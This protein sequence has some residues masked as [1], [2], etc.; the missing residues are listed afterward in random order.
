VYNARFLP[1]GPLETWRAFDELQRRTTSAKSAHRL[2]KA[3]G[4]LDAAEAARNL[5]APTLILHTRGDLVWSF[6]EAKELH[7]LIDRSR[8][9]PLDSRNHIL[10]AG[11]SAF[12]TFLSEV[13]R[14]LATGR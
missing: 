10:Q 5:D 9:V 13:R 11:E 14:F 4:S 7:A 1:D 6:A 8:L 3:F 12:A 2:W